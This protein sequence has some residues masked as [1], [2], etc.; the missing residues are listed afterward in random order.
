MVE[1]AVVPKIVGSI[2]VAGFMG[3]WSRPVGELVDAI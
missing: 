1:I 2:G 3:D